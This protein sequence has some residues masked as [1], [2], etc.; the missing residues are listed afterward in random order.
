TRLRT[1][2]RASDSAARLEGTRFAVLLED[3]SDERNF[4]Q[5]AERIANLFATPFPLDGREFIARACMSIA[6][7]SPEEGADDLLR[8]SDVALRAAKRRGIGTCEVYDPQIHAAALRHR[9]LQE[10]LRRAIDRGDLTLVYQP[11]VIL[12][13]RRIAGVEA[14]VRW[15]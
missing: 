2:L 9:D 1:Y 5:V 3:M 10:E 12:R 8:N 11:I 4:V 13:S 7:A 14:L 6:S 15:Q